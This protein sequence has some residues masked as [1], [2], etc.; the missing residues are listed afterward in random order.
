MECS[1]L[2]QTQLFTY[3]GSV[4]DCVRILLSRNRRRTVRLT[5]SE[6]K[7]DNNISSFFFVVLINEEHTPFPSNPTRNRPLPVARI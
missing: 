6:L 2:A 5:S 1:H 3:R 4:S 7:D